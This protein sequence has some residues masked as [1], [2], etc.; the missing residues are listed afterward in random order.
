MH[1]NKRSCND[2]GYI[3]KAGTP[4]LTPMQ[5]FSMLLFFVL[6]FSQGTLIFSLWASPLVMSLPGFAAL[7]LGKRSVVT[8][9]LSLFLH[10][11]SFPFLGWQRAVQ[12]TGGGRSQGSHAHWIL[13]PLSWSES[14]P[15]L[16]SD[17]H[18]QNREQDWAI[19]VIQLMV[20][21]PAWVS[22]LTKYS[23]SHAHTCSPA[24]QLE[25]MST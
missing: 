19:N 24:T 9:C 20:P 6:F 12:V 17:L 15:F 11:L 8:N 5:W 4:S 10:Q 2:L 18:Q 23:L 16:I 1:L 7:F 25:G 3:H 22:F 13:S 21:L 14:T